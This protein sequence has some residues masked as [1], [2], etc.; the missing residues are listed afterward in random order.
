MML[1]I[2]NFFDA[3]LDSE[4]SQLSSYLFTG[5]DFKAA[6]NLTKRFLQELLLNN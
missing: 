1:I 2:L 3:I 5:I 4:L 6:N